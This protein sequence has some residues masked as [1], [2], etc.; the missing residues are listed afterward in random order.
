MVSVLFVISLDQCSSGWVPRTCGLDRFDLDDTAI[1][2]DGTC[3]CIQ[4]DFI[5][6]DCMDRFVYVSIAPKLG[7]HPR[8]MN[9]TIVMR[10]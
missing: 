10:R 8:P 2:G 3:G 5:Y 4:H 1:D 7:L 9:P 6:A